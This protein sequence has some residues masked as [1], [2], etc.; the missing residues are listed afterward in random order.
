MLEI[1]QFYGH[2]IWNI[3]KW[4]ENISISVDLL[5]LKGMT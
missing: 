2:Q 1:G 5:I 4:T 3:L